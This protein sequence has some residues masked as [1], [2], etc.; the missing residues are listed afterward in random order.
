MV[1][2]QDWPEITTYVGTFRGQAH[3]QEVISQLGEM[4]KCVFSCYLSSLL[5]IFMLC[6][7]LGCSLVLIVSLLCKF[8]S[9]ETINKSFKL[10]I[11]KSSKQ[12][13]ERD[14]TC[15]SG[16]HFREH[17]ISFR[18]KTNLEPKQIVFY[19]YFFIYYFYCN[20]WCPHDTSHYLSL[21][22]GTELV[23]VNFRKYYNTKS[24]P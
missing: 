15:A 17:L 13:Q 20:I 2:S 22:V 9:T 19:R 10:S 8:S 11:K 6:C 21:C 1:A 7:N 3:R 14:L 18:R 5:S 16:I 24:M 23:K 12:L 4:V